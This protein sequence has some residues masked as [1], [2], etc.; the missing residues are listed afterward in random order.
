MVLGMFYLMNS[1]T[2][3]LGAA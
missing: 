3:R 1:V 2:G